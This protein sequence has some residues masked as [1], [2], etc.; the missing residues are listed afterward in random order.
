[1][2]GTVSASWD[3]ELCYGAASGVALH[4]DALGIDPPFVGVGADAP[5]RLD[6]VGMGVFGGVV[7]TIFRLLL[8]AD[9][10]P[11]PDH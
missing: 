2:K 10:A 1:M 5:Q 4:S 6:A 3:N 8:E 11:H 9:D 7:F